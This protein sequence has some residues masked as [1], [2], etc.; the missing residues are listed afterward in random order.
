MRDSQFLFLVSA[1]KD[2]E[3][4]WEIGLTKNLDPIKSNHCFL[5]CYRKELIGIPAGKAIS[6]AIEKN[7]QSLIDELTNDG[8]EMFNPAQGIS[9]DL[10]LSVLEEIYD[11]WL[12]LYKDSYLFEKVEVLLTIRKRINLSHPAIS[13]GLTGF[14]AEWSKKLENLHRYRP[15]SPRTILSKDP[16][17]VEQKDHM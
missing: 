12:N 15:A 13:K 9:Y 14:T 16:M 1:E 11:F 5:E 7:I 4:F 17:W 3:G 6:K 10:P 8:Y 2:G